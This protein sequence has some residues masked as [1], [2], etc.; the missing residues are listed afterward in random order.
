[1]YR[2][3]FIFSLLLFICIDFAVAQEDED[4]P[5]YLNY[6]EQGKKKYHIKSAL[7]KRVS[8]ES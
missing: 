2:R 7:M 6:F 3:I 1:M 5:S 4:W 8:T